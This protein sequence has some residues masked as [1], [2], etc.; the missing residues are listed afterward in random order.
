MKDLIIILMMILVSMTT[1]YHVVDFCIGGTLFFQT[2]KLISA[3]ASTF[4]ILI[5]WDE[6]KCSFVND[7]KYPTC[8][9]SNPSYQSQAENCCE[10]CEYQEK[11]CYEKV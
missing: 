1:V 10:D 11:C 9:K 2:I 8:F 3:I 6:V 7:E 5:Y 4:L